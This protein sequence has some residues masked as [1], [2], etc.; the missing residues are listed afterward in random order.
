MLLVIPAWR[1][2]DNSAFLLE[3]R[4]REMPVG[5]YSAGSNTF[6]HHEYIVKLTLRWTPGHE[7]IEG[8][9]CADEEAKH[10]AKG[11]S[12][13]TSE[14]PQVLRRRLPASASSLR[15]NFKAHLK[16]LAA[17]RC[18]ASA[19]GQRM[20]D[21]TDNLLSKRYVDMITSAKT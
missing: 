11:L 4:G 13:P 17:A 3:E 14:L 21:L 20:E 10:P 9:E 16:T 19:R 15:R 18:K 1:D 2:E 5:A 12:S 8:S 6:C 7:G